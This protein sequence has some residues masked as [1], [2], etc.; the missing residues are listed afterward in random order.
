[1]SSLQT[2]LETL[3]GGNLQNTTNAGKSIIS[4][5]FANQN[6]RQKIN[7]NLIKMMRNLRGLP[8]SQKLRKIMKRIKNESSEVSE[9]KLKLLENWILVTAKS[10][11]GFY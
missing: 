6:N 3:N 9:I 7:K 5:G 11:R 10:V 8:K 4:H 2:D 1:M